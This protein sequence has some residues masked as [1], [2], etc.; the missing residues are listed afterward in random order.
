[1][2]SFLYGPTH[3]HGEGGLSW[4]LTSVEARPEVSNTYQGCPVT[5]QKPEG[6]RR[7]HDSREPRP[8]QLS[9]ERGKGL[10]GGGHTATAGARAGLRRRRAVSTHVHPP[11]QQGPLRLPY[12][13][14][15]APQ[16][17]TRPGAHFEVAFAPPA[18][19]QGSALL[20]RRQEAPRPRARPVQVSGAGSAGETKREG[21][22]DGAKGVL[23]CGVGGRPGTQS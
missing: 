20:H 5:S 10:Q 4:G 6:P 13:T 7:G 16:E 21:P 17:P 12:C 14:S 23:L 11:P 3:I 18:P 2:L 9:G 1:M 19:R 8:C 15:T 22:W